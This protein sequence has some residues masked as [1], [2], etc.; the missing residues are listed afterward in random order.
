[1][2]TV[3][4]ISV[5]IPPDMIAALQAAVD[6]GEYTSTSEVIREALRS[7]KFKRKLETLEFDELKSLVQEGIES[8]PG[9]DAELVFSRLHSKYAAKQG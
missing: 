2:S 1:M 4:K 7:W 8:G 9:I 5:E 3:Q 6:S